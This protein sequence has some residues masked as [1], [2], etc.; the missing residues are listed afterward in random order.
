LALYDREEGG[1]QPGWRWG[2]FTTRFPGIH[3]PISWPEAIQGSF[4][5]VATAAAVVPLMMKHFEM[6]FEVAW[7]VVFIQVC[8]VWTGSLI[9][10][11]PYVA[12]W[13][14]PGLPLTLLFLSGYS[15]GVEA[16]QAMTALMIWVILIFFFFG[17]TGLGSK[18][19]EIIPTELRAAIIMGAAIVTFQGEFARMAS[20]PKTLPIVWVVVF[21]LMFSVWFNKLKQKNK[22]LSIL[23]STALLVGFVVAAIIGPMF[24]ELS[25]DIEMGLAMPALV[26]LFQMTSPFKVGWPSWEMFTAA[27]PLAFAIYIIVFGDLIVAQTVV[28]E[29]NEARKDERIIIDSTRTHLGCGCRNLAHLLMGGPFIPLHGPIWTGITVFVAQ[30]YK[31]GREVMDSIFSGTTSWHL[32]AIPFCFLAPVATFMTPLLPFALSITLVLTGFT[33]GYI[34]MM[35]VDNNVSRGYTIFVGMTV[36]TYGVAW[37]LAI[38]VL[39][40]ILL[41]VQK[42]PFAGSV[43]SQMKDQ[44]AAS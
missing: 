37:G 39:A 29:A 38:G 7:A 24:G 13:I 18:F 26:T 22:P 28:E 8:L 3:C 14:T 33:C 31:E 25:F 41:L 5:N 6:P 30:R 15:P 35:L 27:A 20:F 42:L 40:Y 11:D 12:G 10:G 34:A 17:L 43:K 32:F 1:I 19:F 23:A 2:P 21:I 9:F 36:A 16:I 44:N 4:L